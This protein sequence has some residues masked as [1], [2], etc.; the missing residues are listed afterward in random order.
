MLVA[1]P[2]CVQQWACS[3]GECSVVLASLVAMRLLHSCLPA[4]LQARAV[5]TTPSINGHVRCFA[6]PEAGVSHEHVGVLYAL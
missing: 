3:Q 6:N 4:N 2:V 5:I 1:R